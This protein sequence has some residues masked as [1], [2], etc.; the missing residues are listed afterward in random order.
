[1]EAREAF[2]TS[3]TNKKRTMS[4]VV[5]RMEPR[6]SSFEQA[7]VPMLHTPQAHRHVYMSADVPKAVQCP[8]ATGNCQLPRWVL[9]TVL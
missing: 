1:M 8:G 2:R 6:A 5:L 3:K 7:C 9:G 4:F